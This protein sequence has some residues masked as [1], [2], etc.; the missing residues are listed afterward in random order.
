MEEK[1]LGYVLTATLTSPSDPRTRL[2]SSTQASKRVGDRARTGSPSISSLTSG[3]QAMKTYTDHQTPPTH[4]V[5]RIR[6]HGPC[7]TPIM[8]L[9][10]A[11][12][13][14]SRPRRELPAAITTTPTVTDTRRA[15]VRRAVPGEPASLVW[16]HRE[17]SP[18]D[19]AGVAQPG[20]VNSVRRNQG[21]A[22]GA[23]HSGAGVLVRAHD[24]PP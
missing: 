20:G 22:P 3:R 6:I 14:P 1:I 23:T 24:T 16:L 9:V 2:T 7:P 8:G 12:H 19:R 21:V 13:M 5:G 15:G 10:P 4:H 11:T 17:Q 18:L